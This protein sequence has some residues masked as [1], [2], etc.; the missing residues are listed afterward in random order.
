MLNALGRQDLLPCLEDETGEVQDL[1]NFLSCLDKTGEV[2]SGKLSD[3]QAH[4]QPAHGDAHVVLKMKEALKKERLLMS[5][6]MDIKSCK[7]LVS[8]MKTSGHSQELEK[9]LLQEVETRW[10]SVHDMLKS[11]LDQFDEVR[12]LSFKSVL[13]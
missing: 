6:L 5:I 9:R 8:Y 7:D 2:P 3:V 11:L 4:L 1:V 10:N 12:F 13:F